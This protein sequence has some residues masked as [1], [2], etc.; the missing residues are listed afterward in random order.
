[1]IAI[2]DY[3]MNNLFS[4]K[5]A[6]DFLQIEAEITADPKRISDADG[7][8]LPGVGAF[9]EAMRHLQELDLV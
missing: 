7:M 9:P 8:I 6:L 3:Q 1:M 2:V 5:N 4:V